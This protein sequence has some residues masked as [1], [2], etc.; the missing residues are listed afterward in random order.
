[1]NQEVATIP[2]TVAG[3]V[4]AAVAG[5]PLSEVFNELSL[6]MALLGAIGGSVRW[7]AL[8]RNRSDRPRLRVSLG[9]AFASISIGAG[10]SVGI[11]TLTPVVLKSVFGL[12]IAPDSPSTAMLAAGAFIIGIAQERALSFF[13][14]TDHSAKR[15]KGDDDA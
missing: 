4:L 9:E 11:G 10:L 2:L 13:G 14:V 5:G 15:D 6:V 7:L 8:R 1:M 3:T 12:E